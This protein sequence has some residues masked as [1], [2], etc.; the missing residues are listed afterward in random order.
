MVRS[1][2]WLV[3]SVLAIM[4][5]FCLSLSVTP[6]IAQPQ[7]MAEDIY[8]PLNRGYDFMAAGQYDLA[9]KEFEKVIKAD[10]YNPYANNNLAAIAERE[11]QPQVALGYLKAAMEKVTQYPYKVGKQVCFTGGLCTAVKPERDAA[12]KTGESIAAVIGD[13]IKKMSQKAKK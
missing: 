2:S 9:K 3:F 8:T 11:G 10:R 7:P 5:A 12:S 4:A 6:V 1:R 13:N